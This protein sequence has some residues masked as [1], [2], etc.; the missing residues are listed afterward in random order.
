MLFKRRFLSHLKSWVVFLV[1]SHTCIST[2]LA[3]FDV[4][5]KTVLPLAT[6]V[7][8]LPRVPLTAFYSVM[9]CWIIWETRLVAEGRRCCLSLLL[10]SSLAMFLDMFKMVLSFSSSSTSACPR[11][12]EFVID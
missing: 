9:A 3:L 7:N 5:D 12:I 10:F 11:A 2:M 4:G 8:V 1:S 6:C